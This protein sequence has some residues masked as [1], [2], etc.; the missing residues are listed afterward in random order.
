MIPEHR[1]KNIFNNCGTYN[2]AKETV[3]VNV[4]ALVIYK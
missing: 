4:Y 3:V 1:I 2:N